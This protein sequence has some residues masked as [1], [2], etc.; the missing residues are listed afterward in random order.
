MIKTRGRTSKSHS[1]AFM[2][3]CI[4][5]AYNSIAFA[6]E[7]PV[8]VSVSDYK[9]DAGKYDEISDPDIYFSI[10]YNNSKIE[11]SKPIR[12][13]NSHTYGE[14]KMFGDYC[15]G[16]KNLTID[17]KLTIKFYDLDFDTENVEQFWEWTQES[18]YK[19]IARFRKQLELMSDKDK[20]YDDYDAY[21]TAKGDPE[22]KKIEDEMTDIIMEINNRKNKKET[23]EYMGEITLDVKTVVESFKSGEEQYAA[24]YEIKIPET[25]KSIGNAN[26][27]ITRFDG[28]A[29]SIK[30][31]SY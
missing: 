16:I 1:I 18:S 29:A 21:I 17:D 26:I 24:N 10:I 31:K 2:F 4:S 30:V 20:M 7:F 8:V 28:I 27:V 25:D 13:K 9:I 23:T 3:C 5:L 12:D 22:I 6:I 15:E 14:M 11:T 19:Y